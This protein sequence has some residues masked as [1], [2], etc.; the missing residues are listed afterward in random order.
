MT[1]IL[2]VV[3]LW[4]SGLFFQ[5]F[6]LHRYAAHQTFTMSKT[7]EK[8]TYVLTWLF[9]GPSYLSAY[10]YGIMHRIHHA[11][12]DTEKDP[13]SPSYDANLFAMMWKTKNIY[14]DINND[15]IEV[16]KK[17]KI[18]VPQW[19]GFDAFASSRF[20]RLLWG[21]LYIAFFAVFATS[22]WQWL[23]LPVALFMAP[24]H[25][26]IINWFAHI[27]G[28]TNFKTT[29]TSKNLFRFD[30]LMMG[31]GYHN[32]HHKYAA[33]PNFG[34]VHWYEIDVTYSIMKVLHAIGFIKLKPIALKVKATR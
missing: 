26:V 9:Q 27:I 17:F 14:Q 1:I 32:N 23:L 12:T 4:Y 16:D 6:F 34:G 13:H 20:S 33:R 30:F 10:G 15:R 11:Y 22:W 29:D 2:F 25:G 24:V 3:I 7:A 18:N 21:A 28:Y 31:E 5:S 8:I 19:K